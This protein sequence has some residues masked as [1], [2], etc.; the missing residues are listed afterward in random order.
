MTM[1]KRTKYLSYS[2]AAGQL[3]NRRN[4][5]GRSVFHTKLPSQDGDKMASTAV[6]DYLGLMQQFCGAGTHTAAT[7]ATLLKDTAFGDIAGQFRQACEEIELAV[8]EEASAV[9]KETDKLWERLGP[10]GQD[11]DN[12]NVGQ[13]IQVRSS[14]LSA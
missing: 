12:N 5:E 10:P 8:K 11:Q 6:Q 3:Q 14:Y 1:G 4:M 2:E 9:G 7:F 13:D